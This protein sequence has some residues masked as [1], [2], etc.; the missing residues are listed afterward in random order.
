MRVHHR[1]HALRFGL[2]ARGAIHAHVG[3]ASN[4][5]DLRHAQPSCFLLQRGLVRFGRGLLRLRLGQRSLSLGD[6]CLS[7][8][9]GLSQRRLGCTQRRLRLV[10][11]RLG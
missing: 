8:I 6:R 4:R 2:A 10:V 1:P 5:A 7:W 11:R 9:V 3:L